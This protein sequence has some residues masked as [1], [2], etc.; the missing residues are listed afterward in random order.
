[1]PGIALLAL[2]GAFDV[3]VDDLRRTPE[4]QAKLEAETLEAFKKIED[5]YVVVRLER[6]ERA[7]RLTPMFG[8]D[9]MLCEHVP[10]NTDAE[11]D[12]VAEFEGCLHD[13]LD[14]WSECGPTMR[15]DVERDLQ[16]TVEKLHELG[17]VVAAGTHS[18]RLGQRGKPDSVIGFNTLYVMTSRA[19]EPKLFI[20]YDKKA[21]VDFQ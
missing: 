17:F 9:S 8:T 1:V 20:A 21:P 19:S 2:A 6:M 16:R 12:A 15:R 10:L 7:S 11:E 3:T 4:E 13:C 14:A 5:R 18:R